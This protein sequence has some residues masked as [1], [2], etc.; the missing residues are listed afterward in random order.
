M[1]NYRRIK[2]CGGTYFF[3]VV[4]LNRQTNT[5]I[6]YVEHLRASMQ[7]VARESPFA[8]NAIVILPDH[9]HAIWTLPENDNDYSDR[10]K[11]FKSYFTRKLLSEG[12]TSNRC[13]DGTYRLWQRRFWEHTIRDARDLENHINY[14]HY[15]PV[16]HKLVNQ[17]KMWPYSSFHHYVQQGLLESDWGDTRL[18]DAPG[19]FGE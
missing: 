11:K 10:W 13:K 19:D 15:N 7:R 14:I 12:L 5:L 8:T 17:A 3:T 4:M 18:E 9:I 1:V 16:K 6:K 2:I